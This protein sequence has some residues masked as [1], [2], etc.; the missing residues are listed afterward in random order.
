MTDDSN[1][2]VRITFIVSKLFHRFVCF[3]KNGFAIAQEEWYEIPQ[4]TLTYWIKIK[5]GV[6]EKY[7]IKLFSNGLWM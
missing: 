1:V 7:E 3:C 5:D 2:N 4:S 6:I